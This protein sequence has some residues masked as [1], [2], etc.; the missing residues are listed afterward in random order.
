MLSIIAGW[1]GYELSMESIEPKVYLT[2]HSLPP[3]QQN[4]HEYQ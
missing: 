1:K 2:D 3:P 4:V